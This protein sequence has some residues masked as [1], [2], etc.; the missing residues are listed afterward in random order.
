MTM[1]IMI[2]KTIE[3]L[4]LVITYSSVPDSVCEEQARFGSIKTLD[5]DEMKTFITWRSYGQLVM[6]VTHTHIN[7]YIRILFLTAADM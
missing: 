7:N 2:P 6:S 1:A 5:T 3:I 4:K